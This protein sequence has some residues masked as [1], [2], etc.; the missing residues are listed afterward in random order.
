MITENKDLENKPQKQNGQELHPSYRF[1]K[2]FCFTDSEFVSGKDWVSVN[3]TFCMG[4]ERYRYMA[5][6]PRIEGY[7]K[8]YES[9]IA[10]GLKPLICE[11]KTF[12]IAYHQF[13]QDSRF[14]GGEIELVFFFSPKDLEYA[15]GW[16]LCKEAWKAGRTDKNKPR[17][18]LKKVRGI[19]GFMP[20]LGSFHPNP[21]EIQLYNPNHLSWNWFN[22]PFPYKPKRKQDDLNINHVSKVI[23]RDM[24]GWINGSLQDLAHQ[25]GVNMSDKKL[26][27]D[28]KKNMAEG[29]RQFPEEFV[30]YS[31]S[32]VDDLEEIYI[33]KI[34][35]TNEIV[36]KL[37]GIPNYFGVDDIPMTVG[38]L[39]AKVFEEFIHSKFEKSRSYPHFLLVNNLACRGFELNKKD[40][41][42]YWH[43][44]ESLRKTIKNPEEENLE[45][46]NKLCDKKIKYP[47]ISTAGV[48]HWT[49]IYPSDNTAS[50]NAIVMG[51][52]CINERPTEYLIDNYGADIDLKGCY[53]TAL[54]DFYY[55][56]GRPVVIEYSTQDQNHITLRD[57]LK[58]YKHRLCKNLWKVTVST[59]KLLGFNQDLIFS[60]DVS[61]KKVKQAGLDAP[62]LRDDAKISGEFCLLRNEIKNGII[63]TDILEIIE[64]VATDKEKKQLYDLELQ[65]AVF[66][67]KNQYISDLSE[68]GEYMVQKTYDEGM[69]YTRGK[70]QRPYAWTAINIGDFIN[71]LSEERSQIKKKLKDSNISKEQ[72][73][74][75]NAKQENLKTFINTLYGILASL[76]FN[77]GN[78]I[79]ADN[80]TARARV[81]TWM[82][83][84]ALH[85]RQSITDGGFYE[86]GKV[87]Y[88]NNP[89]YLP[90]LNNLATQESWEHR[91]EKRLLKSLGDVDWDERLNPEKWDYNE[92]ELKTKVNDLQKEVD[93]LAIAHINEFWANYGLELK[94]K[95]EHKA[96]NFFSGAVWICK[97][98]YAFKTL[99]PNF[100]KCK[101]KQKIRGAKEYDEETD[102]R[103]PPLFNIF[104]EILENGEPNLRTLDDRYYDHWELLSPNKV[105][106]SL[107]MEDKY[108]IHKGLRPGDENLEQKRFRL[109]NTH[110]RIGTLD[111][112]RNRM[113]RSDS[114]RYDALFERYLFSHNPNIDKMIIRMTENSLRK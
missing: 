85:T 59:K 11:D 61:P 68:W 1:N 33:K 43:L 14:N 23:I 93:D 110:C 37:T 86:L 35:N 87:P 112:F 40:K 78:T 98:H 76:Y 29:M 67:D 8:A 3:F 49:N 24:S 57:F 51:G 77:V 99:F 4:T 10:Q 5:F 58:Q 42:K 72:Y 46:F 64:N 103:Q 102:L 22:P 12:D 27:D 79:V 108:L 92:N 34:E 63:T 13:C 19:S 69:R 45:Q 80:I 97:G 90:G 109:N 94:F 73:K 15:F 53:G 91:K 21:E 32:D 88:L 82:M 55:P 38:S 65:T 9:A 30:R 114:Q 83:S 107:T 96:E 101:Y 75:L 113:R 28:Y 16:E 70:D 36:E 17:A 47:L 66:Y 44:A 39:V 100:S 62:D 25:Q 104:K 84:K 52:R 6:N 81:G 71:T 48:S 74:E 111:E 89:R 7:E 20:C 105:F 95:I 31:Q 2:P 56:I 106:H 26:M 50:L 54:A 41:Q 60:K 18:M